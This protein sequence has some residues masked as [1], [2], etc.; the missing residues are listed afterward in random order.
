MW[1]PLKRFTSNL[2]DC[3]TIFICS[4]QFACLRFLI[5]SFFLK[6]NFSI[7]FIGMWLFFWCIKLCVCHTFVNKNFS[8]ARFYSFSETQGLITSAPGSP[9]MGFILFLYIVNKIR[10]VLVNTLIRSCRCEAVN[11]VFLHVLQGAVSYIFISWL[12][13]CYRSKLNSGKN[14]FNLVWFSISFVF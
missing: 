7:S 4:T 1:F 2:L 10:F 13:I 5:F 3:I 14:Y 11:L 8:L 12:S 6:F 9:R